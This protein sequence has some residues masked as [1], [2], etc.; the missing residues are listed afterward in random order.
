MQTREKELS[1]CLF[2][3]ARQISIQ[4][5]VHVR[6]TVA[7]EKLS[8]G[9]IRK[10]TTVEL[11]YDQTNSIAILEDLKVISVIQSSEGTE[12]QIQYAG[13]T[14]IEHPSL[15]L[16][17]KTVSGEKPAWVD[18]PPA[19]SNFYA[20]VG[21]IAQV[22]KKYEAFSNADTNAIGLL[23]QQVTEPEKSGDLQVYDTVM[24]GVYIASRWYDPDENRYFSLAVVPR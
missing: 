22:S 7:L 11:A 19:G 5:E 14:R 21:S 10:K 12:A 17:V 24:H 9:D 3:A 6:L 15:K 16:D 1:N 20:S 18:N 2:E 23:A 13:N 4:K 8:D